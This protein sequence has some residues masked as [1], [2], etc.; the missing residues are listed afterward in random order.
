MDRE[1]LPTK[2]SSLIPDSKPPVKVVQLHSFFIQLKAVNMLSET[3]IREMLRDQK[4]REYKYTLEAGGASV[5]FV[6]IIP[7]EVLITALELKAEEQDKTRHV[8]YKAI[9]NLVSPPKED[10]GAY[11]DALVNFRDSPRLRQIK[12]EARFC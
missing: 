9:I 10:H 7:D 2:H 12:L 8:F 3:R 6:G 1:N 4:D 5:V 11:H